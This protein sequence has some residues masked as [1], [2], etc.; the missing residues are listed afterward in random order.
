MGITAWRRL[1]QANT[2]R[3]FSLNLVEV[4]FLLVRRWQ[5]ERQIVAVAD[6]TYASLKL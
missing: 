3:H 6:S 4:K 5:P 2:I 1:R